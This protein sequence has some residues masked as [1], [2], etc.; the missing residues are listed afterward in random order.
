MR[1]EW[2][3]GHSLTSPCVLRYNGP[4]DV[5]SW[6]ITMEQAQLA[7]IIEAILFVCGEPVQIADIAH[8]LDMTESELMGAVSKLKDEYDLDKRGLR[9][10]QFGGSL[11]LSIRPELAAYV[12]RLLQPVQ[13]QSLSQAALE[14]L[15]IIAYRQPVTKTE[16]EAVRGVKC[17]YS[18]QSLSNKGLI[19][20][21]G[22]R[23][24][25]G[26][27]IEYGTTEK[28]LSHFGIASLD[29]LPEQEQG[30]IEQLPAFE[31]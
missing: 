25:L 11:Q 4:N 23:E 8:S 21:V 18:V 15:S 26:R 6:G 13:K 29:D 19:A 27:P 3:F 20:E 24:T 9:L 16:I 7:G 17:D 12:E 31:V 30:V 1:V 5:Q 22:R 14:T 28:F 2:G 10:N